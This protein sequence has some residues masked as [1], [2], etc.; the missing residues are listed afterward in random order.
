[1]QSQDGAAS[2][3]QDDDFGSLLE[4]CLT[5]LG[6]GEPVSGSADIDTLLS[7]SEG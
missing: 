4:E 7:G 6:M 5:S 2:Q 1:M 3:S